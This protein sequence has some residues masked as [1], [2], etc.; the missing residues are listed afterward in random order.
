MLE[1]LRDGKFRVLYPGSGESGF[2]GIGILQ[3]DPEETKRIL[4]GDP[5]VKAG[6]YTYEVHTVRVLPGD[7]MTG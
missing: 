1:L 4:D 2:E 7:R 5:A 6:V 3:A